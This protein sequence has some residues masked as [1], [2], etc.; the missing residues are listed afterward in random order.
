MCT[1]KFKWTSIL[2]LI[3]ILYLGCSKE[4]PADPN[5]S[6]YKVDGLTVMTTQGQDL[7]ATFNV[8]TVNATE[9]NIDATVPDDGNEGKWFVIEFKYPEG[10]T[11]LNV[12]P[13]ITDSIDFSIAKTFTINFTET[14]SRVYNVN[15]IELA[16]EEPI[17]TSID[18]P[19][20][21]RVVINEQDRRVE[22]RMPQGTN[23]A[24]LSPKFNLSPVTATVVSETNDL[25]F[26]QSQ[27]I[28]IRNG[29]LTKTY[30]VRVQDY[31]FTRVN[32]LL[33]RSFA[34]QNRPG[35]LLD[36]PES[37]IAF[38]AE[39]SHVFVAYAG[40]IKKYNLAMPLA[41][42]L[43]LNLNLEGGNRA[44][45]RVLQ[46]M[47]DILFSSNA[48][49][50]SGEFVLCAWQ[51]TGPNDTPR[52]VARV[53]V[54]QGTILQNFQIKQEG[55]VF[56]VYLVDRGPLRRSPRVDPIL[57][58]LD[59]PMNNLFSA[60]KVTSFNSNTSIQ[61]IVNAGAGD[62]PNIE[63]VPL[64]NSSEF[65]F[66]SGTIAPMHLMSGLVNPI[67]FSGALVNGSSVG[68]KAFEFNRGK[69]AMWGVFSWST[70]LTNNRASRFVLLDLTKNGYRNS[71][72]EINQDLA[73]NI[74]TSWNDVQKI[75]RGLGG[76]MGDPG[77][78]YCQTAFAVTSS[79]KLRVAC[80]SAQNGFVVYEL[81]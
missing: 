75:D 31:G 20:S 11:P 71:I 8:S 61:G 72:T 24:S 26:N 19:N 80:V 42:S 4:P 46:S 37:S 9:F 2:L 68:V 3:G 15:I 49:W 52:E 16:P 78:F 53:P 41:P 21:E 33:D 54:P 73:N 28:T 34:A 67:P 10:I 39:G 51:A 59:L 44:P 81:D 65:Y 6:N 45:T 66:N 62:G 79:N 57:Y 1:L 40:G 7:N 38:D 43:D 12:I 70:N 30:T 27:L 17:I 58:T 74:F 63:L 29:G 18:I 77:G 55:G 14:E 32:T 23:L 48:L 56:K 36:S 64:P 50:E 5:L 13:S 76:N 35:Y 69:Y 60:N 25:N 22:V 47:G